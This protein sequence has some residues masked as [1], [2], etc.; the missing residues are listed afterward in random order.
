MANDRT[1]HIL[2]VTDPPAAPG[3]LPRVRYMCDYLVRRGYQVTLLTEQYE[4]LDFAHDYP[5]VAIPMYNGSTFDWAV[6][7]LWTLLTDW[8]NRVFARRA[9]STINFKLSTL[10]FKYDLVLCTSFSDFPLGAGYRIAKRLGVPLLCDIRDLDEQV[11][12]SRYQY[13]H[14]TW[15]TM[16]G[17][18]L[19][20]A[21]HIC[22]R[23]RILRAADAITTVSPWHADFIRHITSKR[24]H[25]AAVHT[26]YNGYDEAQFYPADL[27][28]DTF[29]I[30]YIG[31]LFDWQHSALQLVRQAIRETGLPV[32][33]DIHTPKDRPV[34]HDRLGD[35]IRQSNVMLV[36]TN[37]RT[38]G[39]LTTKFYEA[40]GCDKPILCVPSDQGSLAELIA[41][42]NAGM[43]TDDKEQIKSF[44]ATLYREWQQNGFTRRHAE[45]RD[46]FSRRTQ[47]QQLEQIIINILSQ[48]T[49]K[50]YAN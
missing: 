41:Y 3:Y 1:A 49:N 33:L 40:L 36:L 6:K 29:R 30:T 35:A 11:D 5:I 18:R 32:T 15:W 4:P 8:H 47:T 12:D 14:R 21:I 25:G 48:W 23:N 46:E 17:R 50:N 44:I 34:A 24:S 20:R 19:Y 22:R 13:H 39:M 16:L 45:H 27:P 7:T 10:N 38:H 2:V 42:T 26:V 31:S 37:P 28:T 9:L 43:A